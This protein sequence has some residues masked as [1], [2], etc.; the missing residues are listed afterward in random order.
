MRTLTYSLVLLLFS[1]S[2]VYAE[3][4]VDL[5]PYARQ[6]SFTGFTRAIQEMTVAGEISGRY[7]AVHVD[8]GDTTREGGVAE[9]DPTFVRLDIEKNRIARQKT[10]RRLELEKKTLQRYTSLIK[11]NSTARATY[12]EALLNS[13]IL[14]LSLQELHAEENRLD[15][16][17]KRH[18]L[19][20]PKGWRVIER[21]V[22]P[23]EYVRQGEPVLQ[24]GNYARMSIAFQLTYEQ[25]ELLR[26]QEDLRLFLPDLQQQVKTSILRVSPD[27][28]ARKKKIDVELMVRGS[29]LQGSAG[30]SGLRALL[31]LQGKEEA[32]TFLVPRSAVRGGYDAHWL[33][34]GQG[35]R[36]K[37]ILLGT[38]ESDDEAIISGNSL[39][40][41][42]RVRSFAE[43]RK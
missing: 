33:I 5:C 39:S 9:I 28:D 11:K 23:G 25:L 42:Q 34:D 38:T 4:M 15:E 1:L 35:K 26:N 29:D 14:K 6:L 8:V 27:F 41:G 43:P 36:H 7:I 10:V 32:G 30:R 24:L 31:T 3:E 2:V 37:V 40:V 12:D 13:E 20:T 16:M 22:E 19:R 18:T 17:L 21:F